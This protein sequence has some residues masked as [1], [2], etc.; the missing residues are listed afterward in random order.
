MSF[1]ADPLRHNSRFAHH[2]PQTQRQ[3]W[4][5]HRLFMWGRWL[6]VIVLWI[7]IAPIS[8]WL[9]RDELA[10]MAD[11]FTWVSL[12]Y[13]IAYNRIP[14]MGLGFCIGMTLAV[15]VWQSR[16]IIWGVSDHDIHQLEKSLKAIHQRGPSHPLW[17]LVCRD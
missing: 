15:L 11:Y 9:V 1:P 4:R 13:A 7:V 10:L 2:D 16:N 17:R 6:V 14:F 3:L 12:R 5:L 8:L